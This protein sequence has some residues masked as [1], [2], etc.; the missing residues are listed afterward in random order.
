MS[1]AADSIIHIGSVQIADQP[2][3][4]LRGE[5]VSQK[6]EFLTRFFEET[7]YVPFTEEQAKI[8]LSARKW[9]VIN[10]WSLKIGLAGCTALAVAPAILGLPQIQDWVT[11]STN[12]SATMFIAV[13]LY[14]GAIGMINYICTG[15][16]PDLA[17]MASIKAAQE[18]VK[19]KSTYEEI[20]CHLLDIYSKDKDRA[21]AI[22]REINLVAIEAAMKSYIA[23][24]DAS[25]MCLLITHAKNAVMSDCITPEMPLCIR[26]RWDINVGKQQNVILT[27]LTQDST[28][29]ASD[30]L[31]SL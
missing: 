4:P 12:N 19:A 11:S 13:T 20:A 26:N 10:G 7:R 25:E 16:L 18:L 22:A 5:P 24:N 23:E 28:A 29:L 14:S 3:L 30:A 17:A 9:A 21:Q 1:S 27:A 31:S 2:Y 15:T 8:F 6:L